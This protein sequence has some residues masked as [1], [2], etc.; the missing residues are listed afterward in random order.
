MSIFKLEKIFKNLMLLISLILVLK[1]KFF[2]KNDLF[3]II[4]KF[5]RY[6]LLGFLFG[7]WNSEM[8]FDDLEL[9]LDKS[10]V[11]IID[12]IVFLKFEIKVGDLFGCLILNICF[13]MK[14]CEVDLLVMGL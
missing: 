7:Y 5:F 12:D 1:L 2:L 9:V 4:F 8:E 11:L 3:D 14:D 13:L 6:D 10:L